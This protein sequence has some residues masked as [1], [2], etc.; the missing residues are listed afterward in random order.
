[1]WRGATAPNIH[2]L[3]SRWRGVVNLMLQLLYSLFTFNRRLGGV[4]VRKK[5]N[6]LRF[7]VML[8][9]WTHISMKVCNYNGRAVSDH[10]TGYFFCGLRSPGV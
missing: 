6:V 2:D 3:G 8:Y 5:E 9:C 10:E 7:E 1:M 4:M